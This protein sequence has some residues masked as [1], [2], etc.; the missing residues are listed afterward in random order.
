VDTVIEVLF[1]I[2]TGIILGL[3]YRL[4]TWLSRLEKQIIELKTD[5]KWLKVYILKISN[6][7]TG[8]KDGDTGHSTD[9]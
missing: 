1:S 5:M 8:D 4:M 2:L 3:I 7:N 6:N 9:V